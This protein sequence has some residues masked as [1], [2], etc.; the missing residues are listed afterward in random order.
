M[1]KRN[2]HDEFHRTDQTMLRHETTLDPHTSRARALPER[3]CLNS[4]TICVSALSLASPPSKVVVFSKLMLSLSRILT[5]SEF[6]REV[7]IFSRIFMSSSSALSAADTI[8]LVSLGAGLMFLRRLP[9]ASPPGLEHWKQ[10]LNSGSSSHQSCHA[11][12]PHFV[13]RTQPFCG[14]SIALTWL[15]TLKTSCHVVKC[16]CPAP[17]QAAQGKTT[18]Q[19]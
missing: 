16:P 1:L 8:S 15:S 10:L 4:F 3:V 7:F 12:V 19:R 13:Q 5:L 17:M 9:Q 18:R 2:F 14:P 6:D 11:V